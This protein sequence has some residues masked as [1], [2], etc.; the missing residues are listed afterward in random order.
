MTL[1][2]SGVII[3]VESPS[4][5]LRVHLQTTRGRLV[6]AFSEGK[7]DKSPFES[8]QKGSVAMS[9]YSCNISNVSRAKGST[10][11]ATLSYISGKKIYDERLGKTFYGFGR[12]ERIWHFDVVLPDNAPAEYQDPSVLFN[13]LEMTEKASNAR[14]AKKVMV[15]L[16][17]GV[18]PNLWEMVI[19]D[20][21]RDNFTKNGYCAAY[22]I[23]SDQENHNPHAHILI[24]NRPLDQNGKWAQAKTKKEYALD[25]NGNRIPIIDPATGEQKVDR[26]NRKQWRRVTVEQNLLDQKDFLR[27]LRASW[28]DHCNE[29]LGQNDQIDHRSNA[30]RGI[31]LEPTVHE[32][33]TARAIEAKGGV[34]ELCQVNREI[35]QRNSLLIQIR[36][37]L[38]AIA[39]RI[40]DLIGSRNEPI[41]SIMGRRSVRERLSEINRISPYQDEKMQKNVNLGKLERSERLQRMEQMIFDYQNDVKNEHLEFR[42]PWARTRSFA[43]DETRRY[44]DYR[45][46]LS[47][48][49]RRCKQEG[50]LPLAELQPEIDKAIKYLDS[51]SR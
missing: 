41:G 39:Q 25:R 29:Y 26:R 16:P 3:S 49:S 43:D 48:Y 34:S 11:C 5:S 38:Q 20:F 9:I 12:I 35:K 4:I 45:H 18:D 36:Q 2:S 51:P 1:D 40:K 21:I 19:E 42:S 17:Y 6:R 23:H 28:A 22:A 37:Q 13:S 46:F 15:A 8:S 30:D 27:D 14:T 47:L 33:Y 7:G 32:G 50:V 31:E 24:A 44:Y 10:S